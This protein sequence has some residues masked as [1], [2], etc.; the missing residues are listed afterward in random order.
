MV[1]M[2]LKGFYTKNIEIEL[3]FRRLGMTEN[4]RLE[5]EA[6][7]ELLALKAMLEEHKKF[8]KSLEEEC[9]KESK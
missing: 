3:L 9:D 5:T 2:S 4:E 6:R 7:N 8:L 1:D